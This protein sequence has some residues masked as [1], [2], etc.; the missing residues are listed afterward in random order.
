VNQVAVRCA[1]QGV[2]GSGDG[3]QLSIHT[4][5]EKQMPAL[6]KSPPEMS[7]ERQTI[8]LVNDR[9]VDRDSVRP[10]LRE[11]YAL[12]EADSGNQAVELYQKYKPA[13]VL[14]DYSLQDM[15]GVKLLDELVKRG[16][17]VIVLT[18]NGSER[19]AVDVMK[20]GAEDYLP[21][22]KLGTME[23]LR[24]LRN[25]IS[26]HALRRTILQQHAE[27][28]RHSEELLKSNQELQQFAYIISHDLQEPL[29]SLAGF[30]N[31][32]QDKYEG[33]LDEQATRWMKR[34]VNGADRMKSLIRDLLAVSRIETEGEKF[35]PVDFNRLL[36]FV[37]FDLADCIARSGATILND[38]LP[39]ISADESQLAQVL[40]NLI[41]NALKYRGEEPP[42]VRI[43]AAKKGGV[44]QISV[45]DNGIGIESQYYERIFEMFKRLHTQDVYSGTGIGLALCQR[46]IKR[47]GGDIWVE[48]QLGR[49][50]TFHFTIDSR[51]VTETTNE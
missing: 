46:I 17:A 47:H 22:D 45:A 13:C 35:R 38:N 40:Q 10:L 3:L 6:Q 50:S 31:L 12:I 32:L 30:C 21:V 8:L 41:G 27:L 49:G 39:T 37:K 33:Q 2:A 14:I 5:F 26:K 9:M 28:K 20:H 18:G 25:S 48:S 42:V 19:V 34:I 23:L 43:S 29:R 11:E 51:R 36:Q 24:S 4:D 7:G 15:D 16:A 1:R 44:W